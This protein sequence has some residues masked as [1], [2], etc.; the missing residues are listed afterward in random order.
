MVEADIWDFVLWAVYIVVKDREKGRK[1]IGI[2]HYAKIGKIPKDEVGCSRVLD[3]VMRKRD[4]IHPK[5]RRIENPKI[6][7]LDCLLEYIRRASE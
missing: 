3:G 5:R 4:T 2:K 1:K 7:L 6:I